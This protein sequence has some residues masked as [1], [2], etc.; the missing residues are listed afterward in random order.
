MRDDHTRCSLTLDF[1]HAFAVTTA[2]LSQQNATSDA[3][4]TNLDPKMHHTFALTGRHLADISL[5]QNML[6]ASDGSIFDRELR[7]ASVS[8]RSV[9]HCR[10]SKFAFH[11]LL[12]AVRAAAATQLANDSRVVSAMTPTEELAADSNTSVD[13]VASLQDTGRQ[14]LADQLSNF[15]SNCPRHELD[16]DTAPRAIVAVKELPVS[17]DSFVKTLTNNFVAS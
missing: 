13:A 5:M 12:T 8:N 7:Y 15:A 1:D 2:S 10:A 17:D 14:I 3:A 6:G 16:A 4:A 11:A 9:F